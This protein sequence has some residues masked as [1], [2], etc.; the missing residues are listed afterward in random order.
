MNWNHADSEDRKGMERG[1]K[2]ETKF[3]SAGAAAVVAAAVVAA[4]VAVAAPPPQPLRE[5]AIMPAIVNANTFFLIIS[6]PFLKMFSPTLPSNMVIITRHFS[7]VNRSICIFCLIFQDYIITFM[8]I[9][10][11]RLTYLV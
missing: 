2:F 6:S 7:V 9:S 4:V 1:R 11:T 3:H 10:S 8:C 5:T